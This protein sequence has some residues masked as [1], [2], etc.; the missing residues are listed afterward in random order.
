MEVERLEAVGAALEMGVDRVLGLWGELVDR[1]DQLVAGYPTDGADTGRGS[2]G[3][4]HP[5]W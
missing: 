2:V 1:G 3:F 5:P 4:S